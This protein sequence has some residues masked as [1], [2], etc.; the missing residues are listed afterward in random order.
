MQVQTV[1]E[2]ELDIAALVGQLAGTAG[3]WD[4]IAPIVRLVEA[5]ATVPGTNPPKPYEITE[6]VHEL[7]V[8]RHNVWVDEDYD[9][10]EFNPESR[11]P[12]GYKEVVGMVPMYKGRGH[13]KDG[14]FARYIAKYYGYEVI[15]VKDEATLRIITKLVEDGVLSLNKE[16][17]TDEDLRPEDFGEI[18]IVQEEGKENG[19]EEAR[20][21][22]KRR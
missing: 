6:A 17:L 20:P 18:G 7:Q 1:K 10:T 21:S 8:H 16:N 4:I 9:D 22:S 19:T 2:R 15:P 14:D 3:G 5:G 12:L 11:A 13:T